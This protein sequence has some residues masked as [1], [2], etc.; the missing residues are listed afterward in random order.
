MTPIEM[1]K[2][3]HCAEWHYN[4]SVYS[5]TSFTPFQVVYGCPPLAIPNYIP[6]TTTLEAVDSML[7]TREEILAELRS[8][9]TKSMKQMKHH[10]DKHRTN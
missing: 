10:V 3:L 6:G 1:G 7:I 4:S 5:A 9:L 2:Y 8:N